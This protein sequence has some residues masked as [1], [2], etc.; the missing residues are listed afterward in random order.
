MVT[1]QLA[2][3]T[4]FMKHGSLTLALLET[5]KSFS[6]RSRSDSHYRTYIAIEAP[7]LV[8]RSRLDSRE[9]LQDRHNLLLAKSNRK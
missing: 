3:S 6:F 7:K 8:R 1:N 4:D 5:L 2:H 9:Y